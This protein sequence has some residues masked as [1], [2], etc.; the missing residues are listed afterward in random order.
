[1]LNALF[2][3]LASVAGATTNPPYYGTRVDTGTALT[4]QYVTGYV[5]LAASTP[6]ADTSTIVLDGTKGTVT[7]STG[8][9]KAMGNVAFADQFTG[10]TAADKIIACFAYLNNK[11]GT[12]DAR[13]LPYTQTWSSNVF[14]NL[15]G[16][17]NVELILGPALISVSTPQYVA[18]SAIKFSGAG[19][20]STIL[21][22]TFTGPEALLT[23]GNGTVGVFQGHFSDFFLT[24][25]YIT[26]Y[27]MRLTSTSLCTFER[28]RVNGF[29]SDGIRAQGIGVD[30][31][32]NI[33]DGFYHVDSDGNW[34]AGFNDVGS[35]MNAATFID[36]RFSNNGN[37]GFVYSGDALS[38]QGG[39]IEL[40]T[41]VGMIIQE[42]YSPV[43]GD[44][45][46]SGVYFELNST[47][48]VQLGDSD[49]GYN[50]YHSIVM[51]GNFFN[52]SSTDAIRMYNV[53]DVSLIGNRFKD[54]TDHTYNVLGGFR[55]F[56]TLIGNTYTNQVGTK[57]YPSTGTVNFTIINESS[58]VVNTSAFGDSFSVGVSTLVVSNGKVSIGGILDFPFNAV[59]YT[60]TPNAVANV[61]QLNAT[62]NVTAQNG[63]GA[64]LTFSASRSIGSYNNTARISGA[65]SDSSSNQYGI[66]NLDVESGS[67]LVNQVRIDT[68]TVEIKNA[69]VVD[70]TIKANG[71]TNFPGVAFA[72]AT[73]SSVAFGTQASY[74]CITST[75]TWVSN[76]NV[77]RFN[78]SA[79]QYNG[80]QGT[81]TIYRIKV[82]QALVT[83]GTN[84]IQSFVDQAV[85]SIYQ[86]AGFQC[87]YRPTAGARTACV[88]ASASANTTT[89]DNGE[90]S[91]TE[92]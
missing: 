46:V 59:V 35:D 38:F 75:I 7:A 1:M 26:K 62:S 88:T 78:F 64:G 66:L 5:K 82:D 47:A 37:N 81:E 55:P 61:M 43:I 65:W 39:A 11:N 79:F 36:S 24:T 58:G 22:G 42:P 51:S 57:F 21:D 76:G 40:N 20:R 86:W 52:G 89:L 27:G 84:Q 13:G 92:L 70:G 56:V 32:Y 63:L 33:Y 50:A 31:A 12:C 30:T 29:A 3:V 18:A 85:A 72:S 71:K 19:S 41:G 53:T 83:C 54:H 9:F 91:V 60:S 34:G 6:T 68:G 14:Q 48:C 17:V 73:I 28:I 90:F 15:T 8:A 23:L 67:S 4:T 80:Q 16:N 10:A 87:T 69:L 77:A 74:P 25:N 2:M 49:L 44:A 45:H